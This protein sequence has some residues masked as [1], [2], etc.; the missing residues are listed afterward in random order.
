MRSAS[1]L[2]PQTVYWF[3]PTLGQDPLQFLDTAIDLPAIAGIDR[4]ATKA[5]PVKQAGHFPRQFGKRASFLALAQH[6]PGRLGKLQG[7][8]LRP[9][10]QSTM[11][12]QHRQ[13][14]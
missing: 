7:S 10:S 14:P 11:S 3:G 9:R 5:D 4:P 13:Q 12:R 6:A 8:L 2:N 1:S